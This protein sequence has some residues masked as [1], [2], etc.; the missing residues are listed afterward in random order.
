MLAKNRTNYFLKL[1]DFL[2]FLSNF[3]HKIYTKNIKNLT[4]I[5][6]DYNN[7]VKINFLALF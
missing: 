5:L 3:I 6:K 4:F 2:S 1:L 7:S